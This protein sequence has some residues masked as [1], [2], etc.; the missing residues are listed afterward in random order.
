MALNLKKYFAA[1]LIK[2]HLT[3]YHT[4]PKTPKMNAHVERFNRSIQ[5]EF[6]DY[7]AYLLI[8]PDNFNN[9]LV[10]YLIFII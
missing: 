9:K 5:K 1:Y 8:N 6:V 10:D 4:Y 7:F 3:H 2:L